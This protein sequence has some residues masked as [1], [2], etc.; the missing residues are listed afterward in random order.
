MSAIHGELIIFDQH[1][2]PSIALRVYGDEFYARYET[3]EGYTVVYDVDRGVYCYA[4]LQGGHFV[5]SGTPWA[6]GVPLGIPRH[7]REDREVRNGKFSARYLELRP[8]E[9]TL[10]SNVALTFGPNNGLLRGRQLTAGNVRG[11]TILV[12]FDDVHTD[13]TSADAEAMLNGPNF[14]SHGNFCSV[15]RYY[16]LMSNGILNYTN[17]VVGPIRLSRRRSH[18]IN[19]LL[20]EE[21]LEAAVDDFNLDLSEF[22]SRNEGIVDAL[23]VMYAGRTQYTGDLWPHN[24]VINLSHHGVRTHY[25]TI[26][27]LGRRRVDL[28]IGTFVHESGHMLCRWPDLYDYGQRDGDF[29]DSR[30]L[31]RYCLMSAG[32]HLDGGKTPAPVCVYL[33]DL[34]GW[35]TD[36]VSLNN[37]R[38]F[39]AVHGDYQTC[40]RFDTDQ[41]NE[42]FLIENRSQLGLD[43]H[44][45][46]S[47]LAVF[48]CDTRG[49]NEYQDG[50][51]D[52]H[53][54]CALIQ[55]DGRSD[56]EQN[57]N[58]GDTDDLYA[59]T[60]GI[61]LDHETVPNSRAWN[62][63]DSGLV[64]SGIGPP[65]A[66]I[67]FRTGPGEIDAGYTQRFEAQS[68]AD[69]IIPDNSDVGIKS[70][71]EVGA[72]GA[73]ESIQVSVDI[74]HSYRGDIDIRLVAPSGKIVTLH[75]KKQDPAE[76]LHLERDSVS[77]AA[78]RELAGESIE[79]TWTLEVRDLWEDD[80]G[81]LDQ[82]QLGIDYRPAAV[83]A[84]RETR[85][86][87]EIADF[88][89]AGVVSELEFDDGGTV[90]ALRV[91]VDITHTYRGDLQ[92][93]LMAPDGQQALLRQRNS[94]SRPNLSAV[95]ET[96]NTP[97][98]AALN[99]VASSGTWRIQI[100]DMAPDDTGTLDRWALEIYR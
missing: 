34:V 43:T 56:L 99:G 61:A 96:A 23:S 29:E 35:C 22:D 76:N 20:I 11:L 10:P 44:L 36:Q 91:E 58:G 54:Q 86:G 49:S 68:V 57:N 17:R 92:I 2:G 97:T 42:Y 31:G 47:G 15:Q 50:T 26:Q 83:V 66:S 13:V 80:V 98:L 63:T 69:L 14:S 18:Y 89:A 12:E 100:R 51:P 46:D 1:A 28:S 95:Y 53:Y 84:R 33:R 5:S 30:G 72:A 48:H 65:G 90:T 9:P 24:H 67:A 6:K 3:P 45:P 7:L 8:P 27:S 78:L 93:G 38:E 77:F 39:E 21:A 41:E 74:T 4:T 88:N 32:N 60:A 70:S 52:R 81:R 40:L 94:D 79:G 87:L 37:S 55:A 19:N 64:L 25:Y 75:Q 73:L 82:W 16:D 62:G 71:I 85:P 59:D